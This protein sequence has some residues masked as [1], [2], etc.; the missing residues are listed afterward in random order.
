VTDADAPDK[1]AEKSSSFTPAKVEEG[2][3]TAK[4]ATSHA[5]KRRLIVEAEETPEQNDEMNNAAGALGTSASPSTDS[6]GGPAAPSTAGRTTPTSVS[7]LAAAEL[8]NS[9]AKKLSID[10]DIRPGDTETIENPTIVP[11]AAVPPHTKAA[12]S[13]SLLPFLR[14]T[15]LAPHVLSPAAFP[16]SSLQQQQRLRS[17]PPPQQ[18][19]QASPPP[20]IPSAVPPASSPV[21]IE[22]SPVQHAVIDYANATETDP[23][24]VWNSARQ[25]AIKYTAMQLL[26]AFAAPVPNFSSPSSL[27]LSPAAPAKITAGVSYIVRSESKQL[28]VSKQEILPHMVYRPPAPPQGAELSQA[29]PEVAAA[30]EVLLNQTT[31]AVSMPFKDE[32]AMK[33]YLLEHAER[34]ALLDAAEGTIMELKG[35]SNV[36]PLCQDKNFVC[37]HYKLVQNEENDSEERSDDSSIEKSRRSIKLIPCLPSSTSSEPM[38]TDTTTPEDNRRNTISSNTAASLASSN[39]QVGIMIRKGVG[40]TYPL[41]SAARKLHARGLL[42]ALMDE[43][44]PAATTTLPE[45]NEE[46]EKRQEGNANGAHSSEPSASNPATEA[47]SEEPAPAHQRLNLYTLSCRLELY[48]DE[49][50]WEALDPHS[51]LVLQSTMYHLEYRLRAHFEKRNWEMLK[52]TVRKKLET[53][54]GSGLN[55]EE[56]ESSHDNIEKVESKDAL[57]SALAAKL[58]PLFL[59]PEIA[60]NNVVPLGKDNLLMDF[61]LALVLAAACLTTES[62][63]VHHVS[64]FFNSS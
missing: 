28:E 44:L 57:D 40:G 4:R 5:V 19:Q 22:L 60:T 12:F 42:G 58:L 50:T 39:V 61:S 26:K 15:G 36:A 3:A 48:I 25:I 29:T 23:E 17:P 56:K 9:P 27:S 33:T 53:L 59:L 20:P 49:K 24:T 63:A 10:A 11:L 7:T 62:H 55:E 45:D 43:N 8:V 18:H 2:T 31:L 54:I 16:F 21:T 13:P 52:G 46:T 14:L 47:P 6:G 64:S 32:N 34:A 41:R 30:L 37:L 1:A 38:S 35:A 51:R